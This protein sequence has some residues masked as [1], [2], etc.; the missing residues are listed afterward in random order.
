M[1]ITELLVTGYDG[2]KV[3]FTTDLTA[4][5]AETILTRTDADG[6]TAVEAVSTQR[7]EAFGS[8]VETLTELTESARIGG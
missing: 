2:D 7:S 3:V 1:R 4:E 8:L 6:E 5:G